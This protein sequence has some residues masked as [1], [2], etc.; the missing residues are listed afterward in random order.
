MKLIYS[1]VLGFVLDLL[2]GDSHR[3]IHP[4]QVIGWFIDKIKYILLYL[5]YGCPYEEAKEK[6][7]A[8]KEGAELL[9]GYLLTLLIVLGTFFVIT[10]LLRLAGFI[11]PMAPFILETWLIY[12]ILATKSLKTESMKVYARLKEGDLAGARKEISYL[13]GRDTENLDE[14]EI[15]KADV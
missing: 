14:S 7:L 13:V 10:G 3:M 6:G 12:R 9:A 8:R 4:V 15:A 5:I 1:M 11:H 2:L